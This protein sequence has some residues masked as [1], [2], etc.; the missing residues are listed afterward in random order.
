MDAY[1]DSAII[2]KLY[3]KEA[4]SPDAIRHVSACLAPYAL[5]EWQTLEVRNAV[6][7]K[8]F[9]AEITDEE[10]RRSLSD[11]EQD[12]TLGRWKR[13]SY[14]VADVEHKADELSAG[15]SAKLGCRTLDII[16]VAAALV[17]G[18]HVFVTFDARQA[19]LAKQTGLIVRP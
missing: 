4:T 19:V 7:L 2:V 5:T 6:R 12:I 14:T 3:V 1:F 17:I 15:Y 8:A 16:H 18:I 11:F 10:M 13:P 9:R